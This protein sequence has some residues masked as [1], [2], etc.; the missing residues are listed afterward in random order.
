[1]KN[2][3]ES[4][5]V[6]YNWFRKRSLDNNP[7]MKDV[8]LYDRELWDSMQKDLMSAGENAIH[9]EVKEL[10]RR[11]DKGGFL[12]GIAEGI[13]F[14]EQL[15]IVERRQNNYK[16]TGHPDGVDGIAKDISKY[17]TCVSDA[18]LSEYYNE[19]H[20]QRISREYRSSKN[21]T[22]E[23]CLKE[24]AVGSGSLVTHHLSYKLENGKTALYAETGRELMALCAE[25]C[26]QL[27]DIARY[28]RVGRISDYDLEIALRPLFACVR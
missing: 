7:V 17:S 14:D 18:K 22:C 26:H 15:A 4:R 13:T 5:R 12:G 20:W 16:E 1:M 28:I 11:M 10:V 19:I 6:A 21:W 23:L 9:D 2:E 8:F 25:P 24:H 3:I 27:A